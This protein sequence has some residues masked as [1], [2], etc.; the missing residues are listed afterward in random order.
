MSGGAIVLV[1]NTELLNEVGHVYH[2]SLHSKPPQ[3]FNHSSKQQSFPLLMD[4]LCQQDSAVSAGLLHA[5]PARASP[6]MA[7]G[8]MSKMVHLC[9]WLA[10]S[11]YGL[12]AL[13][14][15]LWS[16]S[17]SKNPKRTRW[18]LYH[19]LFVL[20]YLFILQGGT[21]GFQICITFYMV[22]SE[23]T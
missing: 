9:G 5:V 8:A 11:G 19:F 21:L 22:T 14:I 12:W 4:L 18:D 13:G 15:S 3:N 7:G 6:L 20:T 10:G 1:N 17:K 23:V 16:G 2:L